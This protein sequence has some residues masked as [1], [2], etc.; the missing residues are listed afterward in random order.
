[1]NIGILHPGDMGASVGH[2]ALVAGNAVYWV[3]SGRSARTCARAEKA[4]L[5]PCSSFSELVSC[6]ELLISVCPPAASL[7]VAEEV[8]CSEFQGIFVEA[9]AISPQKSCDIASLFAETSISYVDG[10]L[11]GPPSWQEG[12]TRLY[13]SGP[14]ALDVQKLMNSGPLEARVIDQKIGS[15]SAM[16]QCFAAFTKG[17]TALVAEVLAAAE[18]YG[19]TESLASEW[20]EETIHSRVTNIQRIADRAWRWEGEMHEIAN[21]LDAA[22]LPDGIHRAAA[23]IY[24]RL[25]EFRD[26]DHPPD[27]TALR[28]KILTKRD[29]VGTDV[30]SNQ[31][32]EK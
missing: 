16:K 27:W 10:G 31:N 5:K 2:S 9:N 29:T 28:S 19:V 14:Q 8:A 24:A 18:Y 11:V 22:G 25:A 32:R 7:S 20:G 1:M 12:T 4:N 6:C 15:A 30:L 21:T 13:L 26:C 23:E 3:A 17:T